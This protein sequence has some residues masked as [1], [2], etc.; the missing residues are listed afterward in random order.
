M[1]SKNCVEVGIQ[2][3][4]GNYERKQRDVKDTL[5]AKRIS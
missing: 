4:N 5:S 3:L 1:I 2:S